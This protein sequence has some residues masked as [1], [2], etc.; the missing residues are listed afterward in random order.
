MT[1]EGT[2]A[3]TQTE[4]SH[5]S[6]LVRRRIRAE[7]F[8][9]LDF[10]CFEKIKGQMK[11]SWILRKYV[12][13]SHESQSFL[14]LHFKISGRSS[15]F[16]VHSKLPKLLQSRSST[17]DKDYYGRRMTNQMSPKLQISFEATENSQLINSVQANPNCTAQPHLQINDWPFVLGKDTKLWHCKCAANFTA[18][19][20]VNSYK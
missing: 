13:S 20:V 9:Q 17:E 14:H 8:E 2:S 3:E 10:R 12:W 19:I 11:V 4:C 18:C 1:V 16:K 7:A 5:G 6:K 15:W